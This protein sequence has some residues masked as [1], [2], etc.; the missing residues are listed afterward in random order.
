MTPRGVG[1]KWSCCREWVQQNSSGNHTASVT[2]LWEYV[3][4]MKMAVGLSPSSSEC[5][6]ANKV[7][8]GNSEDSSGILAASSGCCDA[9]ELGAWA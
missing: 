8:C 7:G 3:G 1:L 2:G 6:G 9:N 4:T 5:C